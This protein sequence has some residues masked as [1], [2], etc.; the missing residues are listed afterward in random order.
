MNLVL[1]SVVKLHEE[2]RYDDIHNLIENFVRAEFGNLFPSELIDDLLSVQRNNII[3]FKHIQ[4]DPIRKTYKYDILG[5]IINDKELTQPVEYV[6][7]HGSLSQSNLSDDKQSIS[8]KTT[9]IERLWFYK[10]YNA[11]VAQIYR[12]EIIEEILN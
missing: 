4:N 6:F 2:E 5:Y 7:G 12:N 3:E 9:F 8:N 11:G 10:R 1:I